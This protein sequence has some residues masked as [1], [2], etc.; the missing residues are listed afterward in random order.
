MIPLKSPRCEYLIQTLRDPP[1]VAPHSDGFTMH[2][3][4]DKSPQLDQDPLFLCRVG[5]RCMSKLKVSQFSQ[6]QRFL[7]QGPFTIPATSYKC[8]HDRLRQPLLL[9]DAT[10][11][12]AATQNGFETYSLQ[13]C[14]CSCCRIH[15]V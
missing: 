9:H 1:P 8:S 10:A 12:A 5:S 4:C 15:T 14:C 7:N 3:Y 13:Q 6:Y 2:E 11:T